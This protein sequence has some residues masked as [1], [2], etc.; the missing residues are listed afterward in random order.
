[1]VME[2]LSVLVGILPV[3]IGLIALLIFAIWGKKRLKL[4]TIGVGPF[5]AAI[6]EFPVEK[7][8]FLSVP[9]A[10]CAGELLSPPLKIRILDIKEHPVKKKIVRLELYNEQGLLSSKN[11]SGQTLELSDDNGIVEFNNLILKRTGRICILICVDNLEEKTDD[12]D[13]FPPGLSLDFWNEQVGS[14]Q[15]E[16]KL[17]RALRMLGTR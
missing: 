8:E 3:L 11:Y 16:E 12:I 10:G 9:M 2:V 4:N 13:I 5:H 6:K 15:Y 7:I 14:P 1:M 17:T